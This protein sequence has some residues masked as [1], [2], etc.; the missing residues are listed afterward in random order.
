MSARGLFRQLG[1]LEHSDFAV[2]GFVSYY[3]GIVYGIQDGYSVVV[4]HGLHGCMEG[5]EG[6]DGEIAL[7]GSVFG[8]V[9]EDGDDLLEGIGAHDVAHVAG[10]DG[11]GS[12]DGWRYGR[13]WMIFMFA[14]EFICQSF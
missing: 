14:S 13:Q 2:E 4:V 8:D 3:A 6:E 12:W 7:G 5:G 11:F 10:A 1:I 9:G